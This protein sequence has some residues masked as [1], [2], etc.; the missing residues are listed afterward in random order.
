M[1]AATIPKI[2]ATAV[3][4]RRGVRSPISHLPSELAIRRVVN[5]GKRTIR[6]TW[7][8][9]DFFPMQGSWSIDDYLSLNSNWRIEFDNGVVEFLAMPTMFHEEIVAHIYGLLQAFVRPRGLGRVFFAGIRVLTVS[10]K[11]RVP[12]LVFMRRENASRMKDDAWEGADLVMEIVSSDDSSR[13]WKKKRI[14]YAQAGIPEYWII[15]PK[16][17]SMTVLT[18]AGDKYDVYCEAKAGQKA[19]SALLAGFKVDVTEALAGTKR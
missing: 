3:N 10:G 7:E 6:P 12:D 8:V 16:R 19:R 9:A 2:S 5:S 4:D 13:D 14:E 11:F 18:L 1:A 15:D 17:R